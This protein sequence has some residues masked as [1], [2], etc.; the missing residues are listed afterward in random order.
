MGVDMTAGIF[1]EWQPRYAA[2]G[3]PTFPVRIIGRDKVPM[4]KGYQRIGLRGS[5]ELAGKYTT[6][7]ALGFILGQRVDL[8]L[9]DVDTRDERCLADSLAEHGNSPIIT[10]TASK[11]GFH[12]WYRYSEAAWAHYNNTGKRQHK[13]RRAIKPEP[14][15]PIDYLGGGVAVLPPSIGPKGRYEFIQGSLDDLHRLPRFAGIVPPR[16]IERVGETAIPRAFSEMFEGDGRHV[17]MFRPVLQSAK[18]VYLGGGTLSQL[19]DIAHR[20]NSRF[21]GP[22][23]NSEVEQMSEAAWRMTIEGRNRTGQH[24]AYLPAADVARLVGPDNNALVLLSWLKANEGP[25]AL[26]WIA[27]GLSER[28]GMTRKTLSAARGRLVD[29]RY[30]ER[31]RGASPGHPA[32]YRW[33]GAEKVVPTMKGTTPDNCP[34]S[35]QF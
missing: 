34:Q 26:F 8:M 3:I 28:L 29:M 30:I 4:S 24:G 19:L 32:V 18:S 9:T 33:A 12:I 23:E 22:M 6:A 17:A 5:T 13:P 14:D 2:H 27:N 16:R 1:A 31:V 20:Y 21:G 10:Q 11:G 35:G 15:R 7:D 25:D